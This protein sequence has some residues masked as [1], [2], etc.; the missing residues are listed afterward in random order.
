MNFKHLQAFVEVANT[1]HFGRASENL[2]M[3]QSGLSQ[4]IKALEK[5]VGAKLFAR[6]T[7]AI[8]LTDV[9]R[10]FYE[11][12]VELI[13]AHH[14][15]EERIASVLSGDHGTVRLGFIASAALGIIPRLII[16]VR[17]KAPRISIVLQEL[18]SSKQLTLLREGHLD[19]GLIREVDQSPGL[20]ISPIIREPLLLAIPRKHHLSGRKSVRMGELRDELFISFP[21]TQISY[22]HSKVLSLCKAEGFTPHVIQEAIQFSTILGLVSSGIG[23]AIVPKSVTAIH[24]PNL[25]FVQLSGSEISSTIYIARRPELKSSPAQKRVIE[26][27]HSIFLLPTNS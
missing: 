15:A 3:T 17:K 8:A 25:R 1:G 5:S 23:I 12:A 16:G 2:G 7:R 9:G 11:N 27:A 26:I 14:L 6:T 21:Q 24:L 4:M 18:T 19:I 13:Q 22:L 20:V 10:S